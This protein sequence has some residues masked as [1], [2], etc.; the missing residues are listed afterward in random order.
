MIFAPQTSIVRNICGRIPA[1]LR[2]YPITPVMWSPEQQKLEGHTGW[3]SAVAF[4]QDR[5]MLASASWDQTVR[6]WHPTTGQELQKLEGH[7]GQVRAVSF[8]QGG[9]IL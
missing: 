2:R 1:W 9:P 8:S 4:S 6:L 7:T 5:S 3:V